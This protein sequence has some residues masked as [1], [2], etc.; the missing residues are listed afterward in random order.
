[1][2]YAEVIKDYM[3]KRKIS[4]ADLAAHIGISRQSL[5][6]A[7]NGH[8]NNDT[9]SGKNKSIS[10]RTLIQICKPL[11]LEVVISDGSKIF[12]LEAQ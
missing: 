12:T 8:K 5:W 3:K 11:G 2:H 1:M 10:L 6:I 4:Y 7:L 9:N